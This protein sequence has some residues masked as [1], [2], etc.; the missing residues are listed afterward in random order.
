MSPLFKL[1]MHRLF[2]ELNLKVVE[3]KSSLMEQI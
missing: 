2:N 1:T 3:D